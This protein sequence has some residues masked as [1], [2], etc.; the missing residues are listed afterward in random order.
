VPTYPKAA[1]EL[2]ASCDAYLGGSAS[3]AETKSAIW[4]AAQQI[5]LVD[6][7]ELRD[8][9]QAAEGRLDL[10]EHTT[11]AASV[12]QATLP[13]VREVHDRMLIYLSA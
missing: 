9:L 1:R 10:I 7:R 5:V 8:F 4:S 3:L 12:F 11:D 2:L 13:V 6:E